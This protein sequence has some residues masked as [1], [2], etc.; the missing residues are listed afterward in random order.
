MN[1]RAGIPNKKVQ[2]LGMGIVSRDAE[3]HADCYDFTDDDENGDMDM[4]MQQATIIGNEN[5]SPGT[6]SSTS[7]GISK[8]NLDS[9][10]V[11]KAKAKSCS[12]VNFAWLLAQSY[13]TPAELRGHNC[14]G[15]KGK[16]KLDE[17]KLQ[18]IKQKVLVFFSAKN[19]ATEEKNRL[20]RACEKAIDK[21]IRNV[22][23]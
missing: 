16:E 10:D 22:Y 19:M 11:S 8:I 18:K 12:S 2:T 14:N 23:K 3:K 21:G 6:S 4:V 17:V 5:T 7:L 20:W 15:L 13:F 9:P 1:K